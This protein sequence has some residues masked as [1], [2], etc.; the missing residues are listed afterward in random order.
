ML[1]ILIG[2]KGSGKS[3]IGRTLERRLGVHFF[4]VEPLWMEYYA[5]CKA[6]G[7]Q[8]RISE[9]IER[10]HPHIVEALRHHQHVCIETTGASPEILDALLL[11][12]NHKKVL[13]A[14]VNAPLELCLQRI[15]SRDQACQIPMDTDSIRKVHAL[16]EVLPLQ[17]DLMIENRQLTESQI[18]ELFEEFLSTPCQRAEVSG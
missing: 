11:L 6:V 9:G 7:K 16:S 1:I 10:V 3:H 4:H 2:P 5:E 17:S 15:A 13:L 8:P 12:K 18:V 14:R